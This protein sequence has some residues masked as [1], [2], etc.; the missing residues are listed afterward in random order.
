MKCLALAAHA[1]MLALCGALLVAPAARPAAAQEASQFFPETGHTVSGAFLQFWRDNGGLPIFGYPISDERSEP[2]FANPSGS[3]R[4]VQ[5]FERARFELHPENPPPYDVLLGRLG[6]Q[7]TAGRAQEPPFRPLPPAAPAP[8][9]AF[10]PQT[11]HAL[12]FGFKQFWETNGGLPVFGYPLSE[13]FDER[14]PSDGQT[15]TVQYFER[16]RFEYHPNNPPAYQVQLGLLGA[17]LIGA[18]PGRVAITITAGGVQAAIGQ[19]ETALLPAGA[20]SLAVALQFPQPVN[21]QVLQVQLR[22]IAGPPPWQIGP[23]GQAP[24]RNSYSFTLNGAATG[25]QYLRVEV[26]RG[27]GVP[28]VFFGIQLGGAGGPALQAN[29][30]DPAALVSSYYN[31]VNRREYERAWSYWERTG[32]PN[33]PPA[34]IA[35]FVRGYANTTAVD[36]TTGPVRG[37]GA[38]GTIYFPV[39]AVLAARQTDGAVA[40]FFGCYLLT[41]TN[42]DTGN[43]SPP[44]PI[45]IRAARIA[46]AAPNA[47]PAALLAAAEAQ[48]RAGQCT[49]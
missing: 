35:D 37:E 47:D 27:P 6:A 43:A 49:E 28:A 10:F 15:Y 7:V 36:V 34:S 4:T 46:A 41:R 19:D 32:G 8:D 5:W 18:A 33:T 16:A 38:A 1:L 9:R 17:Q 20:T 12:A 44:F 2:D 45:T 30:N 40:R 11:G 42:V 31:A 39:P 3:T 22:Q 29:W 26:D 14:N 13:E 23:G 25:P 48:V 24:A 21:P